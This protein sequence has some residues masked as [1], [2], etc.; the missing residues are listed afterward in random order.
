M[1]VEIDFLKVSGAGNDFLLID[2]LRSTLSID[3]PSFAVAACSRSFGVGADGI[4]VLEPSDKAAFIMR[5]FNAD[6]SFGGMC[7]N[8]GRCVVRYAVERGIAGRLVNFE[9][10]ENIYHGEVRGDRV[11]LNLPDIPGRP[12]SESYRI[13]AT[14]ILEGWVINTGSP[15]VVL[16]TTSL[17]EVDILRI[18]RAI[19]N[20]ASAGPE[21]TNVNFYTT[22][23]GVVALRTYERGVEA[24]TL[25]CG[26]GAVAVAL[27]SSMLD[28]RSAPVLLRVRS[29]EHL[30]VGFSRASMGYTEVFLEGSAHFLFS[31]SILYDDK[32]R[33]VRPVS[34]HVG[35]QGI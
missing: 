31:G 25:A 33:H 1:Q 24:E 4:L 7:G 5:Y 18:G 29:G 26:T 12:K 30:T 3:W 27:V 9:A 2:N 20:H 32:A 28:G 10:C 22:E 11:T 19:R 34:L 16:K 14:E 8:G 13:G 6:G 21:G 15:H 35:E 23:A 17:D